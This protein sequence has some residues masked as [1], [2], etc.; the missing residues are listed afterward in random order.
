MSI[1]SRNRAHKNRNQRSVLS[2]LDSQKQE[3]KC[4]LLYCLGF[5]I[6]LLI[7]TLLGIVVVFQGGNFRQTLVL[8]MVEMV[9]GGAFIHCFI[10]FIRRFNI[11]QQ[12][13]K[14]HFSTEQLFSIYCSKISF[15]YKPILKHFAVIM[16][17]I[18]VDENGYKF[19]YVY[20]SKES[21]AEF[22]NKFIK[23]Q[24]L[25]KQIELHCYKNTHI[26]KMLSI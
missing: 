11:F 14:I 26:I 23:Q 21:P 12:F 10:S 9:I 13:K 7:I 4:N 19:Y 2:P 22:A 1:K 3:L 15:L 16:C 18:I 8:L 17:V 20:P 24:F 25:G 5:S 6:F